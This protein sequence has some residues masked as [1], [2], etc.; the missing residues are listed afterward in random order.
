MVMQSQLARRGL[1]ILAGTT[2]I[3]AGAALNVTH[4]VEGGQPLI[5]PMTG[6]ILALALASVAAALIASEAWRSGRRALAWCLVL[7]VVAGEGFGLIMGA[8]RLLSPARSAS[9]PPQ[10]PTPHAGPL[11]YALKRPAQPW[12]RL[13]PPCSRRPAGEAAKARVRLCRPRRI[14]PANALR[15]PMQR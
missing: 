7:S 11:R 14:E 15:R 4:L 3:A 1:A 6:A 12:L 5:S 13:R 9:A 2:A 10:P 8:E